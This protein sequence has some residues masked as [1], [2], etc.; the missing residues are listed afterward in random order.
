MPRLRHRYATFASRPTTRVFASTILERR[1]FVCTNCQ[2]VT[3]RL[4]AMPLDSSSSRSL[5]L[6]ALIIQRDNQPGRHLRRVL[7]IAVRARHPRRSALACARGR[8]E[9]RRQTGMRF[10]YPIG[11]VTTFGPELEN[12]SALRR[13][14]AMSAIALLLEHKRTSRRRRETE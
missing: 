11:V 9:V 4:V 14:H 2:R 10:T 1:F 12:K 6:R 5:V 8:T 7:R 3:H 13:P